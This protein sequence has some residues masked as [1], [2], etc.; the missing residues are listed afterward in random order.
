[1]V[2]EGAT[3]AVPL[4]VGVDLG[5]SAVEATLAAVGAV[6]H[7]DGLDVGRLGHAELSPG[8]TGAAGVPVALAG[9]DLT[10]GQDT[11]AGALD[12]RAVADVAVA[13]DPASGGGLAGEQPLV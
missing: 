4:A 11:S 5:V 6:E 10:V 12:A 9:V 8:A 7:L 2:L 1:M 13:G 3:A